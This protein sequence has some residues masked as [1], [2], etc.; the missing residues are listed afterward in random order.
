MEVSGFWFALC[1][2]YFKHGHIDIYQ[3]I[4]DELDD[5]NPKDEDGW[6]PLHEA[7]QEGHLKIYDLILINVEEKDPSDDN[8]VTP[9]KLLS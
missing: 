8:G 1:E 3:E 6:T 9:S 7:A 5:K 2:I 4:I